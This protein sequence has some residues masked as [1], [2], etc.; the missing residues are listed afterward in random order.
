MNIGGAEFSSACDFFSPSLRT[1][2][3][4]TSA[5]VTAVEVIAA[6]VAET[7]IGV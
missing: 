5:E 7:G 6:E 2:A 1:S 3:E 4:V